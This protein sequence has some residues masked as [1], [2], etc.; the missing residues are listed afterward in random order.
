MRNKKLFSGFA[1]IFLFIVS[2]GFALTICEAFVRKFHPQP[3][4]G[5]FRT[6]SKTNDYFINIPNKKTFSRFTNF[7]TYYDTD[8]NGWRG[9]VLN[10]KGNYRIAF[11]GDS[12][13]FGLYL[14]IEETYPYKF[15]SELNK[16][17]KDLKSR[18]SIVNA[19]VPASGVA[20]WL[21]YLQDY[22]KTL[23]SNILVLGVNSTSFS[24]AY[25]NPLFTIDCLKYTAKRE[26]YINK[27]SKGYD[28]I[29]RIFR[30]NFL[31][32]NS[33][34]YY[35]TRLSISQ[36]RERFF[37]RQIDLPFVYQES[38][39]QDE[40]LCSAKSYLKELKK[41]SEQLGSKLVI[42]NLGFHESNS[43]FFS[44]SM[45]KIS[46][47]SIILK[48][49]NLLTSELKIDYID[50]SPFIY[51]ALSENQEL[52]IPGD[53]HPNSNGN[54]QVSSALIDKLVPIIQ[55]N[56]KKNE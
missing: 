33:E 31:T 2:I 9:G 7:S 47:D 55:Q 36:F 49:L 41:I 30:E 45:M 23:D 53:G 43:N 34:L 27:R 25:K 19:A 42:L 37:N 56:Y 20:Q 10:D 24:R 22:G 1:N 44:E 5:N 21:A 17:D 18:L 52:V 32:N 39:N 54:S 13:T 50:S 15:Y 46:P 26:S 14:D 38:M 35:L 6:F 28:L 3:V 8:S 48:N 11:L 40:V 29:S 16:I 12:Y 51:K 4:G